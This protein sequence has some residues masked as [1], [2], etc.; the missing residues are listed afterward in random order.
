ME[1]TEKKISLPKEAVDEAHQCIKLQTLL[2]QITEENLQD[3]ALQILNSP[4]STDPNRIAI[5][6]DSL[7]TAATYRPQ[8]VPLLAQIVAFLMQRVSSENA[9]EKF[10]PI[11]SSA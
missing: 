5:L 4:F 3:T 8:L 9:L 10:K 11:F 7:F 6:V 2:E 1:N